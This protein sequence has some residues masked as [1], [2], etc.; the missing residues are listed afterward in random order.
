MS[1]ELFVIERKTTLDEQE[2][3]RVTAMKSKLATAKSLGLKAQAGSIKTDITTIERGRLITTPPLTDSEMTIWR[4][5]LPTAYTDIQDNQR[6]WLV[7]YN[8]DRIPSPV[9]KMWQK[10]KKSGLF[11]RFE[12]WTPEIS[13]PDPILVGVNGHSRYLLARWGESDANL[14]SFDDIKRELMR[15]WH[16]DEP[17][18][19]EPRD[20]RSARLSL[21]DNAILSAMTYAICA[22]FPVGMT[23]FALFGPLHI[24][25]AMIG[26]VVAISTVGVARFFYARKSMTEKLL[27]SSTLVQAIAKDNSVQHELYPPSA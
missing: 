17:I 14:V 19:H 24:G 6:H 5:W 2:K 8:Y 7:D 21:D 16:N 27:Q 15:R 13:Q 20:E 26:T 3:G 11:E 23:L 12:I 25:I 1:H 10:Y 4:A 18:G 22:I 9:L